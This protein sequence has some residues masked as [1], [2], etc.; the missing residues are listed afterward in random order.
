MGAAGV[1]TTVFYPRPIH[2]QPLYTR[3]GYG[4]SDAPVAERLSGE[5]LALPVHPMLREE[6]LQV[7]SDAV[8]GFFA[9]R[10]GS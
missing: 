9:S 8:H 10:P 1:E 3:L 5:V 7:I 6:D 2:K 4:E